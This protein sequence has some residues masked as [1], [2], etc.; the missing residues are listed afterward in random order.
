MKSRSIMMKW[1]GP[2]RL[3]YLFS[4]VVL[5]AL[6]GS[7]AGAADPDMAGKPF[8]YTDWEMFHVEDGLP[9]DHIF[10]IKSDGDRVWIGTEGG[11][12]LYEK[13]RFKTW[14][15]EDGLPWNVVAA[16]AISPKTG[17]VWLGL[18][19]GGLAR[20]SAGRFENFNQFNSGL[21]NDVVYGVTIIDDTVWAA[22]TAGISSYDTVT[23]T[24]SI[25]N[26]KNAPME[27]IW[28]YNADARDGKVY[29]AVWGGGVL[30]WDVATKRWNAHKDPDREMEIDLYRDDGLVHVITTA[31]SYYDHIL[32]V[33]T[34]FGLSR[35]DGRHWRGY[36]DHDS[37]L[38]SNFINFLVSRNAESCYLGTDQGLS[39]LTDFPS[40][41]WVT[42]KRAKEDAKTWSAHVSVGKDEKYSVPTTLTLPNDFVISLEFQGHDLWIGTG[43]GLA[44]ASGR[45]YYQGLKP[46]SAGN[47]GQPGSSKTVSGSDQPAD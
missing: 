25:Y 40:D 5:L 30:E 15:E 36:L 44:R 41:T 37:G 8:I 20:F 35:Y 10:A 46:D 11:L 39:A 21:V 3:G 1:L 6:T 38:V 28:C 24:W 29:V 31:V 2:T 22:T 19:G 23:D 16:I 17:D 47:T 42:Y 32:W 13:G 4:I 34:Y 18:F 9:N 43:H 26:E 14:T 12:A 27:E 45:G 7:P 33:G